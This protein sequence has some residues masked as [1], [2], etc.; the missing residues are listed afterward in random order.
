MINLDQYNPKII[1]TKNNLQILKSQSD[2]KQT[3]IFYLILGFF[4]MSFCIFVILLYISLPSFQLPVYIWIGIL[5]VTVPFGISSIWITFYGFSLKYMEY[6]HDWNKIIIN[7]DF[8]EIEHNSG[9]SIVYPMKEIRSYF[10]KVEKS[11]IQTPKKKP[12]I[13]LFSMDCLL[14]LSQKIIKIRGIQ[15]GY[16]Q[17]KIENEVKIL[18]K[19]FELKFNIGSNSSFGKLLKYAKYGIIL[20]V[21]IALSLITP[22]MI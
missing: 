7:P 5:M 2:E 9:T 3:P 10:L 11:K 20:Y 12:K 1:E 14:F 17:E 22:L 21:I 19:Y 4:L 13:Y 15:Y 6:H 18:K 8:L 16:Q